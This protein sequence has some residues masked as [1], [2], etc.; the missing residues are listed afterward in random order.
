MLAALTAVTA[1]AD[2]PP[3]SS[4]E[5]QQKAACLKA[6]AGAPHDADG[7]V[8]LACLSRCDHADGGER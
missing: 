1:I 6:C 4:T 3:A 5:P 7:H 2:K 8:L